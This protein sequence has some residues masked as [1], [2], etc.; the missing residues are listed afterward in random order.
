M[1][2][3][4]D[5]IDVLDR[6]AVPVEKLNARTLEFV[7][8]Y[9]EEFSSVVRTAFLILH[10]RERARDIAQEAFVELFSRWSRISLYDRPEAWVRRVAIRLAVRAARREQL[11]QFLERE[12]DAP[13]VQIPMDFDVLRAVRELPPA[14]RAA[15]VL[16]YFEDRPVAEVADILTCSVMTAKVH[17]HRAR[18]RLAQRLGVPDPKEIDDD[19]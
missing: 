12:L 19:V 13:S 9:R 17:L 4:A 11:R 3:E 16:F 18:K 10:D 5:D 2:R 8:F 7:A 15:V 6:A 1:V 14:Q